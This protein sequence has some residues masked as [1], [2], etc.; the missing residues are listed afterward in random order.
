M[1]FVVSHEIFEAFPGAAIGVLAV[2]DVDNRGLSE[3]IARRLSQAATEAAGALDGKN[4]TEHPQVACWRDAYRRFGAKPKKYPS[5]VE[6]LLRRACRG[7][8][9]RSINKLVDLYNV[10]S[11]SHFVP[12]G[13]EDLDR[14]EGDLRLTFATESEPA[15]KLL[16]ESDE[17]P[18]K[19][20]EVIYRDDVG[21]VCR[22]WN[23]KEAERT[24]LTEETK[25]AVLVIETLPPV[26]RKTLEAALVDLASG[27]REH[28]GGSSHR[29][30]LDRDR[31][32]MQLR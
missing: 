15:V 9:I 18:P 4:V 20:G 32:E 17:R 26:T 30:I 7:E 22:R 28:L 23:W 10:V 13:G 25:N 29:E 12:A 1:R 11:L 5:S 24:K 14:I 3:P 8:S 16:G 6:N 31:P 2:F 19:R 21:A 27:V